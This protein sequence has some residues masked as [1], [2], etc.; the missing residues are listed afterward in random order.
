M[1]L[2]STAEAPLAIRDVAK[3]IGATPSVILREAKSFAR[4]GFIQITSAP[5]GKHMMKYLCLD[6]THTLAR[7]LKSLL[8]K[9]QLALSNRFARAVEGLGNV[10]YLVLVGV[11]TG[12]QTPVDV[13]VVGRVSRL[14]IE[15]MVTN[16]ERELGRQIN[17]VVLTPDEFDERS[18]LPDKFLYTILEAHKIVLVDKLSPRT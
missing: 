17:Y 2:L 1:L 15:R 3:R 18:A 14:A 12:V 16:L 11:F 9:A 13:L 7:E 6:S 4:V 10:S 8:L 5:E